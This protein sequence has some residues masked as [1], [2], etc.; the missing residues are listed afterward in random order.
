MITLAAGHGQYRK[1]PAELEF[2][3]Q[4]RCCPFF[5]PAVRFPHYS[6]VTCRC[7]GGVS[8]ST[9]FEFQ[10]TPLPTPNPHCSGRGA[11][12]G[13]E[14]VVFHAGSG[15]L[16]VLFAR[17]RLPAI[18]TVFLP[19]LFIVLVNQAS[20]MLE[21][22]AVCFANATWFCEVFFLRRV[23]SVI[24]HSH[25]GPSR[26]IHD[27]C[28]F[29]SVYVLVFVLQFFFAEKGS[30]FSFVLFWQLMFLPQIFFLSSLI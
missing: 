7:M 20:F 12:P 4:I 16:R 27:L 8:S 30:I 15:V 29:F 18:V 19:P 22:Q 26:R 13:V 10:P 24:L 25:L 2:P 23:H 28:I 17:A 21:P 14:R 5:S 11:V 1:N 6:D 9:R 3:S